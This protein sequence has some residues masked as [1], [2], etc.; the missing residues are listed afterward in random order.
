MATAWIHRSY[1]SD[2]L[3]R[4]ESRTDAYRFLVDLANKH[5]ALEIFSEPEDLSCL[6]DVAG[7]SSMQFILASRDFD[8]KG[9]NDDVVVL[10]PEEAMALGERGEPAGFIPGETEQLWYP[11]RRSKEEL[12]EELDMYMRMK[13]ISDIYQKALA[14]GHRFSDYQWRKFQ[15]TED[16]LVEEGLYGE[17]VNH[18]KDVMAMVE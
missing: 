17:A 2:I 3:V 14:Y 1:A 5:D 12:D 18:W 8:A 7:T 4:Y 6:Y 11:E 15:E 13:D 9:W 10:W 16:T